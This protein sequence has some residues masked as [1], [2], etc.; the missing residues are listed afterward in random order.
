MPGHAVDIDAARPSYPLA[1]GVGSASRPAVA[2]GLSVAL[3]LPTLACSSEGSVSLPTEPESPSADPPVQT[4]SYLWDPLGTVVCEEDFARFTDW[5]AFL[6]GTRCV[7]G[8]LKQLDNWGRNN[9]DIDSLGLMYRFREQVTRCGDQ[10]VGQATVRPPGDAREVWIE[11]T[12]VWSTNYTNINPNCGK[13][14]SPGY[15]HVLVWVDPATGC[16]ERRFGLVEIGDHRLESYAPGFPQCDD[17]GVNPD[18][19][20][21]TVRHAFPVDL[22]DGQPHTFRWHFAIL[23]NDRYRIYLEVDGHV[24]HDYVTVGRDDTEM[25]LDRIMFGS[26]RNVGATEDM[27][28]WWRSLKIWAR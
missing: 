27:F 26:N 5:T 25:K 9:I 12:N 3:L 23:G 22:Y 6:H 17:V 18:G 21:K 11:W 8:N 1:S 15:K 4:G 2:A 13:A 16:G 28:M 19:S 14:P 20:L 24:T 10:I 7:F